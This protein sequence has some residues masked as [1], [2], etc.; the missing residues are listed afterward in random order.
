MA[1]LLTDAMTY[2]LLTGL[3]VT[4][5]ALALAGRRLLV[6]YRLGRLAQ[7]VEPG[8]TAGWGTVLRAEVVEVLAQRECPHRLLRVEMVSHA[9]QRGG[10][11]PG[12]TG[13]VEERA[14]TPALPRKR[15]REINHG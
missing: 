14:P 1:E 5:V 11:L 15:G 8:R 2:R 7:P 13:F 4:A 10:G 6:L 12:G 3:L 9:T